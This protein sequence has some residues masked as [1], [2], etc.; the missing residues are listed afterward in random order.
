MVRRGRK[1]ETYEEEDLDGVCASDGDEVRSVVFVAGADDEDL[2]P[3]RVADVH[4]AEQSRGNDACST[5]AWTST[6]WPC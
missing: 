4:R 3:V 5:C 2:C 6:V 1:E